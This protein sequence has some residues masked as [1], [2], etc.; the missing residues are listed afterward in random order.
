ML[1]QLLSQLTPTEVIEIIGFIVFPTVGVT[2]AL[3][4][5]SLHK[6]FVAAKALEDKLAAYATKAAC[7]GCKTT[8]ETAETGFVKALEKL[9][10]TIET[11]AAEVVKAQTAQAMNQR[12][13]AEQT[14]ILREMSESLKRLEASHADTRERLVAIETAVNLTPRRQSKT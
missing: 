9:T 10:A 13:S 12:D 1:S 4:W 8:R 11:L 14:R 6:E 7:D 3:C 2:W 5:W